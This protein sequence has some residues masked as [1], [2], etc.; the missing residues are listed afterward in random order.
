MP[1]EE[2]IAGLDVGTSKVTTMIAI[3]GE[4]GT[5]RVIGWA[6]G[7][8]EGIRRGIVVDMEAVV[9]SVSKVMLEAQASA[10]CEVESVIVSVSGGHIHGINS[11][12]VIAVSRNG[13]EISPR[14]V[15]RVLEAAGTMAIPHDREVL[16]V[17]K[18][19]FTLDD[20]KGI[21]DP[22]GMSGIRLEA[23]VHLITGSVS[24]LKNLVKS[25]K[26]AGVEVEDLILD[27]LADSYSVFGE[28]EKEMG[29]AVV[30]IGGDV[31]G[32]ALFSRGSIRHSGVLLLGGEH[33][34][35]DVAIV[36]RM[37]VSEA[38]AIKVKEGR[39]IHEDEKRQVRNGNPQGHLFLKSEESRFALASVIQSRMEEI[40]ELVRVEFEKT[41]H[42]ETIPAGVILTGGGAKLRDLPKLAESML[43][44]PTRLG[45]PQVL[46][47]MESKQIDPAFATVVGL[48][49]Y[50]C[51]SK[52]GRRY[53]R[54]NGSGIIGGVVDWLKVLKGD[55]W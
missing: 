55:I 15:D 39:A 36:Q 1:K 7:K 49:L 31:T 5:P 48:I 19:E 12:G 4:T 42:F 2:L 3:R 8:S 43:D 14:D 18:Q 20:Q 25:I 16:H 40:F 33:V 9:E 22:V 32:L 37:S 26:M 29:T 27:S 45:F 24:S 23:E 10:G 52:S 34:T 41:P 6:S 53:R 44:R 21:R 50:G 28:D 51:D 54:R 17:I 47:G 46:E 11:R 35:N 30:D 38:E 13:D